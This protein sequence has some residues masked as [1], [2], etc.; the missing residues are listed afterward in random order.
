[1]TYQPSQA[2]YTLPFNGRDYEVHG[3][4]Q[5]ISDIE[6]AFKENI[7]TITTRSID[8]QVR[9]LARLLRIMIASTG[10]QLSEKEIGDA[11]FEVGVGS[12]GYTLAAIHA[13]A[14]LRIFIAKPVDREEVRGNMGELLGKLTKLAQTLE[15]SHGTNTSKSA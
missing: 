4:F 12:D 9:E 10:N 15:A 8:M 6:Y 7:I 2:R 1:M 3:S 14:A 13:H 11:L 5:L